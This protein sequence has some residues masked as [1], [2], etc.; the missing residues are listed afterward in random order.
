MKAFAILAITILMAGGCSDQAE[1]RPPS[2][3]VPPP[4]P[5]PTP[6]MTEP[7]ARAKALALGVGSCD[8]LTEIK[9]LPF[10]DELG[11]DDQFDRMVVNFDGYKKCLIGKI[12][13]RTE[14]PDP[15]GAPS[16]YRYTV[17][18][19]A[20]DVIS[21]SGHFDYKTCIP[22]QIS[23]RWEQIGAQALTD[24]LAIDGNPEVLQACVQKHLGGT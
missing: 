24:W 14:I 8:E 11:H 19:L 18:N 13:D 9:A 21:S 20:Y 10:Y 22:T 2:K 5:P 4:P 16:R 17:G 12:T 7:Q 15:S 23:S 1:G 6:A 3:P